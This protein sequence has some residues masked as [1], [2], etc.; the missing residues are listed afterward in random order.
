MAAPNE[1][2]AWP[3]E[4][5][6]DPTKQW[7]TVAFDDGSTFRLP[8]E[9]LRVESPSAE[10]QGH[11]GDH[12]TIVPGKRDVTIR[13]LESVGNYAV[14]ITFSDGHDTGLFTWRYL[15]ELGRD[16]KRV[17]QTYLDALATRGLAR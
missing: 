11:G 1:A 17:W 10:V 7:L 12:K 9:L 3:L 4:I 2:K 6:L 14:R 16:E 8:A 15:Y 13:A 5:A